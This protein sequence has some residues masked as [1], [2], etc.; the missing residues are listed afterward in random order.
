MLSIC[1]SSYSKP[2]AY[3]VSEL[4]RQSLVNSKDMVVRASSLMNLPHRPIIPFPFRMGLDLL[5]QIRKV[6]ARRYKTEY[7]YMFLDPTGKNLDE[8]TQ[9]VEAGRL[10]TVVGT[11]VGTRDIEVVQKACEVV[12]SA[13]GGLGKLVVRVSTLETVISSLILF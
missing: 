6:S 9:Y 1:I 4:T 7:S 13:W 5:D 2:S 3:R 8:L 12:H 11:I 10:R